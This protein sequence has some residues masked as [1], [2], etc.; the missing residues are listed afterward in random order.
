M[1]K[2]DITRFLST[3]V[4]HDKAFRISAEVTQADGAVVKLDKKYTQADQGA[5]M[6]FIST[7]LAIALKLTFHSLAEVGLS[8]RTADHRE[9]ILHHWVWLHLSVVGINVT[10]W[11]SKTEPLTPP[12]HILATNRMNIGQIENNPEF[13]NYHVL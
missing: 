8:M 12:G 9:T 2:K 6:S 11:K 7:G 1:T 4:G 13:P 10:R 3:M 5:D